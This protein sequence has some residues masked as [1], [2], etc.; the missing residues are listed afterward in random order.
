MRAWGKAHVNKTTRRLQ[1]EELAK[2]SRVQFQLSSS[3]VEAAQ[4]SLQT[5]SV[6]ILS[7]LSF[8]VD[9]RTTKRKGYYQRFT[10]FCVYKT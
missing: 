10:S 1:P 4:G 5:I 6:L 9:I 7:L 3:T 2:K 8:G